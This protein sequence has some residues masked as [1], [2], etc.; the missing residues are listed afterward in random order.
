MDASEESLH[1]ANT[2]LSQAELE[3]ERMKHELE[4]M[5]VLGGQWRRRIEEERENVETERLGRR[6]AEEELKIW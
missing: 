2:S 6:K 4:E 5:N 1:Q 3:N